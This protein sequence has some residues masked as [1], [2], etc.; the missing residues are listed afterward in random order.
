[1]AARRILV[2][3]DIMLDHF[4]WGDVTRISPE[5]PVP[6][7][8]VRRESYHAGGCGNVAANLAALGARPVVVAPVGRDRH[9]EILREELTSLKINP[10]HLLESPDRLTTK[11]TRIVAHHQ[12]VVRF[13]REEETD[14]HGNAEARFIDEATAALAGADALIVSDYDKGAITP[15]LLEVLLGAARN[16]KIIAGVDPKRRHFTLYR[17]ATLVTPNLNEAAH[18]VDFPIRTDE[19]VVRAGHE[20][21]ALLEA[22]GLLL[23]RGEQGM[24]LFEAA[25][26]VTHIPATAREVF[27]VTG[28]GDTVIA[29]AVLALAAGATLPEAAILANRAAGV[30]IGKLGTGTVA[31]EELLG[32][33][34]TS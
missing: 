4:V 20:L 12:Q 10:A 26:E 2:V 13:D 32:S 34:P 15:R 27:D 25:G 6:V 24:S 14:L 7:V 8:R 16:A 23:T 31:P 18:A 28:A 19:D 5:A 21:R 9:A 29:T 17:P 22:E 3:G 33:A 1:M 11:K 30:A